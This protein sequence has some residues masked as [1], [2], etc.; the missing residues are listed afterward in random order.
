MAAIAERVDTHLELMGNRYH[1][2]YIMFDREARQSKIEGLVSELSAL[3]T[4]FGRDVSQLRFMVPDR[5]IETWLLYSVT[6]DGEFA[7]NC[8][9]A[10]SDEFEGTR[11]ESE[12][13]R[14]LRNRGLEYHKTTIGVDLFCQMSAMALA[15]VSRSF[16]AAHA[17]APPECSWING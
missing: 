2:V 5:K 6:A 1:P 12:L 13:I 16:R 17:V 15:E 8:E 4:K 7:A 9:G 10:A 3:L 14:R 11:G